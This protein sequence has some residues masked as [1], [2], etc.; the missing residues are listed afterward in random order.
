MRALIGSLLKFAEGSD[1]W[2]VPTGQPY[3]LH[4][5]NAMAKVCGDPDWRILKTANHSFA[6]GVRNGYLSRLPRTPAVFQRKHKWKKYEEGPSEDV[7]ENYPRPRSREDQ[8]LWQ[9]Q[10]EAQLNRVRFTDMETARNEYGDSLKIA[11]L[12]AEDEAD[13]EFRLLHDGTHRVRVNPSIVVRDQH[14]CPSIA[15]KNCIFQR[16]L[17]KREP[18]LRLKTDVKS[19]HRKRDATKGARRARSVAMSL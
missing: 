19:A 17:G 6:S 13:G 18:R 1:L 7:L 10:Q 11:A 15:E 8:I 9:F 3:F 14:G 16:A 2:A 5:T 12:L 4:A